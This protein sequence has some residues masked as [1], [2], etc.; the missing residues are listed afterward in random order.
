MS[1]NR[2]RRKRAIFNG[3][4]HWTSH[5]FFPVILNTSL[6]LVCIYKILSHN[7]LSRKQR[8]NWC[9]IASANWI[10]ARAVVCVFPISS[11]AFGHLF[12]CTCLHPGNSNYQE[13]NVCPDQPTLPLR[14]RGMQKC[15][16]RNFPP[17]PRRPWQSIEGIGFI[18]PLGTCTPCGE[19]VDRVH[20]CPLPARA[21]GE[22]AG[23][24]SYREG[25]RPH[26]P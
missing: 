9:H 1:R 23:S 19:M 13:A 4:L 2:L 21:G 16:R 22:E 14:R 3:K 15:I 26:C 24:V 8:S 7:L 20:C 6:L 25:R 11:G 17:N 10:T 18:A 5:W 12:P